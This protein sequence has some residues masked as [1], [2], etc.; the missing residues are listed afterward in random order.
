MR[1]FL[2]GT[3][4]PLFALIIASCVL[5]TIAAAQ[6]Q[7]VA[8]A[9]TRDPSLANVALAEDVFFVC[10]RAKFPGT[11][12]GGLDG[13]TGAFDPNTGRNFAYEDGKW[14]DVK[15]LQ[16]ICPTAPTRAAQTPPTPQVGVRTGAPATCGEIQDRQTALAMGCIREPQTSAPIPARNTL[17]AQPTPSPTPEVGFRTVA[18]ATCGEIRDPQAALALGCFGDPQR[19]SASQRGVNDLQSYCRGDPVCDRSAVP[20]TIPQNPRDQFP[21]FPGTIPYSV[22]GVTVPGIPYG[23]RN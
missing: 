2:A 4:L 17:T 10:L 13:H 1:G 20:G 3:L 22:P 14:I 16:T 15:T 21:G 7:S 23:G 8:I 5:P 18:P 11:K 12:R 19:D 9:M 6:D